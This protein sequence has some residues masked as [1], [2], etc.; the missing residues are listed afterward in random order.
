MAHFSKTLTPAAQAAFV[1]ALRGGALV[2]AAAAAVGVAVSTLY[3]R[4]RRDVAFDA[5]WRAAAEASSGW[6]FERRAGAK[7]RVVRRKRRLRF[8]GAR[9]AAFLEALAS[10]CH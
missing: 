4:R 8:E 5:E 3:C 6:V 1:E 9:R 7:A 2:Q 10:C